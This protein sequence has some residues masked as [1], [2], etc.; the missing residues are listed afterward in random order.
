[1]SSDQPSV[2]SRAVRQA[3]QSLP[4]L[5]MT[6]ICFILFVLPVVMVVVGAFRS[7]SPGAPGNHW[8]LA[9]IGDVYG[10][11][12]SWAV[13]RNSILF[14]ILVSAFSTLLATYLSWLAAR[15]DT[16][17]RSWLTPT[18]VLTLVMP[19]LFFAVSWS[20]LGNKQIGGLNTALDALG[21][22][23]HP[24]NV[25]SWAGIVF[26]ATLKSTALK[27]LLLRGPMMA[28]DRAQ[29]ESAFMAGASK[30]RAFVTVTIP[31]LAP[32]IT[33]AFILGIVVA[34]EY[35]DIPLILG[36]KPHI[37][38]FSTQI[39]TDLFQHEPPLYAQASSLALGAVVVLLALLVVQG[40][41]LSRRQFATVRGKTSRQGRWRLGGWR[42]AGT[43]VIVLYALFG[44]V[45]P[46]AQL[47]LVSLMPF[48]GVYD[49]LGFANYNEV[50]QDPSVVTGIYKTVEL[51]VGAGAVAV[52]LAL[53]ISYL[54]RH[55]PGAPSRLLT[56]STWLPWSVPGT[57]LG[58]GMLW[59]Y[60]GIPGLARLY[61]TAALVL[62]GLVVAATPLAMRTVEPAV[63]QVGRELEEAARLSG[64]SR[65]RAFGHSVVRLITPSLLS[66][67]V[68]AAILV[69]GN[70][71]IPLMLGSTNAETIP[72]LVYQRY[73]TGKIVEAAALLCLLLAGIAVIA[74][75]AF[76]VWFIVRMVVRR[77]RTPRAV[78]ESVPV[79]APTHH[80]HASL[81][82]SSVKE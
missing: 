48:L 22:G 82:A 44:L 51:A 72:A 6:V 12:A 60:I 74:A 53:A 4:A 42:Y 3:R 23:G 17:A 64:A 1:M 14:A 15:T 70:L 10:H 32:A 69:A 11:A 71:L 33:G 36:T 9:A 62:I 79:S 24:I 50:L 54:S 81:I 57:A 30:L 31:A 66:G 7:G 77:P 75:V 8:T 61:G 58:L 13:L 73:S 52:V 28:M 59:A 5:A 25:E 78:V 55:H 35:F 65:P 39:Y 37:D 67:W 26:V 68:L 49:N 76:A 45:L 63:T 80:E 40:R 43:A 2:A 27:Y 21:V 41:L 38:V 20:L 56:T 16:P 34:L 18:M 19:H 47:V 46:V 29:E